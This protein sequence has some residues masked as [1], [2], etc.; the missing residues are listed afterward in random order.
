M[1]KTISEKQVER[2]DNLRTLLELVSNEQ[3]G[4]VVRNVDEVGCQVGQE[5]K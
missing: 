2:R 4:I 1:I 3:L 5:N